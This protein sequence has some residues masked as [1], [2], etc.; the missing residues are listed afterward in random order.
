[1]KFIVNLKNQIFLITLFVL[2]STVLLLAKNTEVANSENLKEKSAEERAATANPKKTVKKPTKVVAKS[3]ASSET[4]TKVDSDSTA[5]KGPKI[6]GVAYDI[7]NNT[8]AGPIDIPR[9]NVELKTR[10]WDFKMTA[11]EVEDLTVDMNFA[12]MNGVTEASLRSFN[13]NFITPFEKCDVDV[14]SLLNLKEFTACLK[15]DPYLSRIA[16]PDKKF[17]L[18]GS[19]LKYKN[20]AEYA[21]IL[22]GVF[23]DNKMGNMNFYNYMQLRL[24]AFSWM[25]CSPGSPFIEEAN[26]ECAIEKASGSKTMNRNQARALFE[27]TMSFS[28]SENREMDFVIFSEIALAV[29][30][31]GKLNGK[32]DNLANKNEMNLALDNN[33]LPQR[34]NQKTVESFFQ[35]A[36]DSSSGNSLG[37]D[38]ISF[39][40]YDFWLRIFDQNAKKVRFTLTVDEFIKANNHALFPKNM[41]GTLKLIPQNNLSTASYNMFEDTKDGKSEGAHFVKSFLQATEKKITKESS[42]KKK[43]NEKWS[44]AQARGADKKLAYKEKET[45]SNIFNTLDSTFIGKIEFYDFGTFI[46]VLHMFTKLD[47][48]NAKGRLVAGNLEKEIFNYKGYPIISK[49][50]LIR[51]KRIKMLNPDLYM[52]FASVLLMMR[53]ED[54]APNHTRRIDKST[55]T[56][57]ELKN[58]LSHV[59]R[60]FIPDGHLKICLR[61]TDEKTVPV[62]DYECAFTTTEASTLKFYENSFDYLTTQT[63]KIKLGPTQFNNKDFGL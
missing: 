24:I 10:K 46:Q 52:D 33:I 19:V 20:A 30:L 43:E 37:I 35:L 59:N 21:G 23:D 40:F 54:I 12:D 5:A 49:N 57:I 39:C 13:Y 47:P 9:T 28:G 8:L 18:Q 26:F 38:L 41:Q 4:E 27:K 56:E 11:K 17:P 3:R 48:N 63:Q 15:T 55:M 6:S 22:Y 7:L 61:Q 42:N 58:I 50:L 62:Y 25:K 14:D 53:I 36:N 60:K 44:L 16:I 29:R 51:S 1:M 32:G 34:Y 31:Y 45:L 2:F